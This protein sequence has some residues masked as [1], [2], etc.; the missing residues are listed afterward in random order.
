MIYRC[1]GLGRVRAAVRKKKRKRMFLGRGGIIE[2]GCE[3]YVLVIC[4]I[5]LGIR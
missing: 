3:R 2:D 4:I 1:R 5:L